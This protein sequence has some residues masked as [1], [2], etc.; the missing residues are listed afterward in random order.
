MRELGPGTHRAAG[1]RTPRGPRGNTPGPRTLPQPVL[2]PPEPSHPVRF[3]VHPSHLCLV[4]RPFED[5]HEPDDPPPQ[6]TC[7]HLPVVFP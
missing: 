5:S 2:E 6:V 1:N 4:A 3:G 7:H